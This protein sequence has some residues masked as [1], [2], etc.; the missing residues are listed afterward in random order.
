MQPMNKLTAKLQKN[1]T[2]VKNIL[3]AEDILVFEFTT[4]D[5]AACAAI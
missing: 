4:A 1:I 5:G 2:A 3:T